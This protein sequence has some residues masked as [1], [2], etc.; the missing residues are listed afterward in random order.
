MKGKTVYETEETAPMSCDLDMQSHRLIKAIGAGK[1]VTTSQLYN[2]VRMSGTTFNHYLNKL[3][4]QGLVGTRDVRD[5]R[6]RAKFC[7]LTKAGEKI[8]GSAAFSG[9]LQMHD[10]ADI[11]RDGGFTV[12][13]DEDTFILKK[14]SEQIRV[15]MLNEKSRTSIDRAIGAGCHYL[16][17]SEDIQNVLLQQAASKREGMII[18]AAT[19]DDFRRTGGFRPFR[20]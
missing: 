9:V 2:S 17:A 10:V 16:C 5:G 4:K 12:T 13:R 1:G 20:L 8:V 19:L 14:N 6:M 7:F 3:E 18:Y 11:F 15:F